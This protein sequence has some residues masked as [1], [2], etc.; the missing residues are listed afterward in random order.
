[1]VKGIY[2][3]YMEIKLEAVK[4]FFSLCSPPP[5]PSLHP[6]VVFNQWGLS[7]YNHFRNIGNK[8][9]SNFISSFLLP[10]F[11]MIV[12]VSHNYYYYRGFYC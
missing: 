5:S 9:S 1:M 6:Y 10:W 11:F 3:N 4:G 7:P 12:I 2:L 8:F